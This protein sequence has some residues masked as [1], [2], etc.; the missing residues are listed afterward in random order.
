MEKEPLTINLEFVENIN[1]ESNLLEILKILLNDE[2]LYEE[3]K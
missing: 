3:S 2:N 1:N